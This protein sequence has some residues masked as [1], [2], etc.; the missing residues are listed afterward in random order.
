MWFEKTSEFSSFSQ[1]REAEDLSGTECG[2]PEIVVRRIRYCL[3]TVLVSKSQSKL[4]HAWNAA[5]IGHHA[6]RRPQIDSRLTELRMVKQ[7][8]YFA[9]E[10]QLSFLRHIEGLVGREVKIRHS[11]S[12]QA[13][14]NSGFIAERERSGLREAAC[15]EPLLGPDLRPPDTLFEHP[16][17]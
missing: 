17:V 12:P 13:R 15:V 8:E 6:E 10:L 11:S 5:L 2:A 9:A 7:V 3:K 14:V 16:A 1:D 4:D